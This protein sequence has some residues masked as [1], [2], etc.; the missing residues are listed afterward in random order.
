MATR[1]K[2]ETIERSQQALSRNVSPLI[3]ATVP[4]PNAGW[5]QA[6][7]DALGM[8][9]AQMAARMGVSQRR[10][11]QLEEAERGDVLKVDTLRRAADALNCDLVYALVPRESYASI[12]E[13]QAES[14]SSQLAAQVIHTMRLENQSPGREST[15]RIQ[16]QR[17]ADLIDSGELWNL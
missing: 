6:T 2:S 1:K 14:K 3:E 12:I 4:R 15:L 16:R 7:R 11:S 17:V 10:I 8:S 13:S 9:R 5:L